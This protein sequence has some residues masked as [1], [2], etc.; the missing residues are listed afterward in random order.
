M[1]TTTEQFLSELNFG[2]V[3]GPI[4]KAIGKLRFKKPKP[5]VVYD[6]VK[7]SKPL[8]YNASMRRVIKKVEIPPEEVD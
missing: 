3:L 7:K 4:G 5:K 2:R 1:Q 6:I 8:K